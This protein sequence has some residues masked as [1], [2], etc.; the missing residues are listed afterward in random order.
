[1]PYQV[2][3]SPRAKQISKECF[4]YLMHEVEGCGNPFAASRFIK[5]YDE[6][7]NRLVDHA[8]SYNFCEEK[9]LR[10]MGIRKARFSRLNYKVFF[11]VTDDDTVIIDLICHDLQNYQNLL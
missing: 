3:I 6:L 5:E 1:M 9:H 4:D 8:S 7:L 11:H 2:D 10:K